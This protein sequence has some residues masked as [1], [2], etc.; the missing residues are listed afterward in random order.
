M[1][2]RTVISFRPEH[3]AATAPTG[4]RAGAA[5]EEAPARA[6]RKGLRFLAIY[7][8]CSLLAIACHYFALLD[9][10]SR[11]N[12]GL[13][14]WAVFGALLAL[15]C[16]SAVFVARR[17]FSR[18][19]EVLAARTDSEHEQILLRLGIGAVIYI[20]LSVFYALGEV[21]DAGL[22]S[23]LWVTSV[24]YIIALGL[25][26]HVIDKPNPNP[27]RRI[28]ANFI[29]TLGLS[30]FLYWG[31]E[32]TSPFYAVYLWVT[33]GCG[34]RYGLAYLWISAAFSLAGFAAV[35]LLTPFWHQQ[36]V[37]SV[38]LLITLV[39]IPAYAGKL[40]RLLHHA[41]TEAEEAS[42]AKSRFLATMS[43]ELRTPL[44]T[45]IGTG[46][47]LKRTTLDNEQRAMARSIRSAARTLLSQINTVLE[48]SKVEAGKI[49]AKSEPFDLAAIIA[50]LD[51]MFRIHAQ[52][53]RL[54]F[55]VHVGPELPMG[56]VGDAD[57]LRNIAVNLLGNALK[58]TERGRV[59]VSFAARPRGG[60]RVLVSMTVGD[61]GI[62]IPREKWETIFES[63]RQA[64]ESISRRFGGTGLGLS[65]VRQ[66]V[67]TMGGT[68][69]VESEVGRGSEFTV[70]LPFAVSAA[71]RPNVLSPG[72]PV[73]IV[74]AA[75]GVA[76]EISDVIAA[77]GGR[78]VGVR[79]TAALAASM[80]LAGSS[81]ARPI[82]IADPASLGADAKALAAA[83]RDTA[84]A[85][86]P[87]LIKLEDP[88][89]AAGAGDPARFDFLASVPRRQCQTGL[90]PL[91]YVADLI[92]LGVGGRADASDPISAKPRRRLHV[93]VAEDNNVN[94]RLFGKILESAGH[95]VTLVSDGEQALDALEREAVDVALMDLN[96]P[97]MSGL[98]AVKL[99][100]FAHIASPR[101]PIIALT[102]DAT[103]EGRRSCEDAG[104]DGIVLK[105]VDA[106]E[107]IRVV[108]CAAAAAPLAAP[109]AAPEPKA[110]GK[111][112]I[113]PRR[114]LALP[115]V[116]D[117][118]TLAAL[119]ALGN[120][121]RFFDDLVDEFIAESRGIVDAIAAAT[122]RRDAE[123]V[124]AQAHA[125]RSSA[126]HFG[127]LRLHQH[128]VSVGGI[129]RDEL[130]KS[131][132]T[133]VRDLRREYR[134]VVDELLREIGAK[135]RETAS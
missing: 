113:H 6:G 86:V 38:G 67:L 20:Y 111:V 24:S 52:T 70:E 120:G 75:D 69:R 76:K 126:A 131:G 77:C 35:Y 74:S 134:V 7:V 13:L 15:P 82:I 78:P 10:H 110:S 114:K 132:K 30:L 94:R 16:V 44:N 105:P 2:S 102:A 68:V 29:D 42:R 57:H 109:V 135:V 81:G 1:S 128:C 101:L 39:A 28:F 103:A 79:D 108:E 53:N 119:R 31:G 106:E 92:A 123:E 45:I 91:L 121:D 19:A 50:E 41:K 11:D 125:L 18:V 54:D 55:S 87:V 21:S 99:H 46:G 60:N 133:F 36:P 130:A 93:L 115:P 98:E 43:H 56:L 117:R 64:D 84:P 97:K 96:M 83:I 14:A 22:R 12:G 61:T 66:L 80:K 85:L 95:R 48:F 104:M 47:L 59:W 107:L 3:G 62:G 27:A 72:E 73:F 100:R 63:F 32:I 122:D 25:M 9:G 5:D 71:V 127:A 26:L 90:R 65:I 118:G 34:F 129:T 58:F 4:A 88:P 8:A 51:A 23:A 116:I 89:A 40:I 17:G 49:A 37:L 124:R 33:L 112:A